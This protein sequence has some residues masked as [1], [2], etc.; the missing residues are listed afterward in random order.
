MLFAND[1]DFVYYNFGLYRSLVVCGVQLLMS[2]LE[3]AGGGFFSVS[4]APYAVSQV[5]VDLACNGPIVVV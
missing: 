3:E 5:H 1:C 4:E 2:M